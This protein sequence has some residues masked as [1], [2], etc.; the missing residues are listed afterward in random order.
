MV[1]DF[2]PLLEPAATYFGEIDRLV[3]A[4][5]PVEEMPNPEEPLADGNFGTA[6][7]N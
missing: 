4:V 2:G 5:S 3:S 1:I 7:R 6:Q